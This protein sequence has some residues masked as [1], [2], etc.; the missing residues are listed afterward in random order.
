MIGIEVSNVKLWSY[1]TMG[2]FCIYYIVAQLK[3]FLN[4]FVVIDLITSNML[5]I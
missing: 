1:G 5:G 3:L 4:M 2:E